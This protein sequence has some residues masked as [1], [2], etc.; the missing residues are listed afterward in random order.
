M[1]IVVLAI[2]TVALVVSR[3]TAMLSLRDTPIA[4]TNI[5]YLDGDD[6]LASR[7][8]GELSIL[9][10]VPGDII[11]DLQRAAVISDPFLDTN[12]LNTSAWSDSDWNFSRSVPGVLI[13]NANTP[14]L[15]LD[16]VK[17]SATVFWND[18]ALGTVSN[19]FLRYIFP[20]PTSTVG[21]SNTLLVSF[22]RSIDNGGRFMACTGG[23]DWAP[24]L[25]TR[26]MHNTPTFSTGIWKSV[27]LADIAPVTLVHVSSLTLY[28]GPYASARL[29][30]GTVS[31][32]LQ[33]TVFMRF[34]MPTNGSIELVG[35][36]STGARMSVPFSSPAGQNQATI[37]MS[38]TPPLLWWPVGAGRQTRYRLDISFVT[39]AGIAV[40]T[41]RLIGF[42]TLALAR[43][44]SSYSLVFTQWCC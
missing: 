30:D 36:W 14:V 25:P 11:T 39:D 40:N 38:A 26:D 41:S 5:W 44:V 42:R 24:M 1:T 3:S 13:G 27:Y 21:V 29:V 43:V 32:I 22:N 2:M 18:V 12:F 17:G 33:T 6:W 10:T 16:G 35:N 23:W 9:A 20:I 15:V 31:F 37:N 28:P 7:A 19:Q 4:A 8:D 34:T